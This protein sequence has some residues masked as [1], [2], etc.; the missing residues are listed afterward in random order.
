MLKSEYILVPITIIIIALSI[1]LDNKNSKKS[2]NSEKNI[3][4]TSLL[5]G[6]FVSLGIFL[7]KQH[8]KNNAILEE[9]YTN[10]PNF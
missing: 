7:S 1:W 5:S 10:P 2:E 9:L 8:S 6:F 3:F 4:K